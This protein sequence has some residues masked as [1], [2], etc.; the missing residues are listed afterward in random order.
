MGKERRVEVVE[1]VCVL[2]GVHGKR[3]LEQKI[4]IKVINPI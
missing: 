4:I 2:V 3:K 1:E